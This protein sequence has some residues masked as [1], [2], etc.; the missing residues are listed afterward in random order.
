MR[1]GLSEKWSSRET[2]ARCPSQPLGYLRAGPGCLLCWGKSGAGRGGGDL[3]GPWRPESKDF[4]LYPQGEGRPLEVLRWGVTETQPTLAKDHS[5]CALE[6]ILLVCACM[7]M[8]ACMCVHMVGNRRG[9]TGG[10]KEDFCFAQTIHDDGLD[11]GGCTGSGK[12]RWIPS[13]F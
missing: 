13:I 9:E 7:R 10:W 6:K 4:G 11:E 12:K 2:E 3:R 1:K 5:S 8:C